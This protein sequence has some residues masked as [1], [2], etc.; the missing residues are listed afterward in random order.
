MDVAALSIRLLINVLMVVQVPH[1]YCSQKD[2]AAFPH[3]VP[4]RLQFFEYESI[5]VNCEFDGSTK[6]RLMRTLNETSPTKWL[7]SETP[8]TIKP[9]FSSDSGEY[10]C[11]DG[12]GLRSNA[13][14]IS[15]TAGSVILESP[16]LPPK[17]GDSLT[18]HCK[19]KH[20]FDLVIADFYKN[21]L[22][23]KTGYKG[24]L[25]I[26]NISTSNEGLYKCTISGAGESPESWLTV[27]VFSESH[28]ETTPRPTT[29]PPTTPPPA[30]PLPSSDV[31]SPVW[32][33]VSVLRVALLL[34]PLGVLCYKI[35]KS[36]QEELSTEVSESRDT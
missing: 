28:N 15:V 2:D 36:T 14:N 23:V 13:I 35:H 9:A 12:K 27:R 25:T 20:T 3:I 11:E 1:S 16:V 4:N 33:V 24:N 6:W 19:K 5:S 32:L 18:L 7:T 34:L 26:H 21:G 22:L 31:V 30:T 17:Q 29:P 10:W 8:V